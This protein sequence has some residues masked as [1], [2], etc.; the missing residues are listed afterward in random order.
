MNKI[1]K[2]REGEGSKMKEVDLKIVYDF[3]KKR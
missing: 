1:K 3:K 2:R